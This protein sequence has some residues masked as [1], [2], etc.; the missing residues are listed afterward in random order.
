MRDL[1]MEMRMDGEVYSNFSHNIKKKG[2]KYEM[3]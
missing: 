2:E 3:A 1:R